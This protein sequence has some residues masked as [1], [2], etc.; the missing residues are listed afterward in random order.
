MRK[1]FESQGSYGTMMAMKGVIIA[2]HGDVVE[3]EFSGGLPNINDSLVVRKSDETNIILEVHDHISS[4]VV[5][6][7]ALGYTQGLKRG[8]SVVSSGSSLKIPVDK[9]CLG[10][11]FNI[12]GEPIDGKP[13][14]ENGKALPIHKMPPALTEQIP[15]SGILET[16]IKIID[17]LS[18][19]P[20]GGKIGL[21]GGAGVGKTVL[22]MEFIYK[23]AKVYSGISIFCG[24]GERVREG[25]ELW[26]EMERQDI[27]GNA[28]L[29]FGEMCE[30]PGIRFRVPLTA[31]T[32]AEF[33]R[34]EIGKDILF[35]MDNIYRFVQ[36]GN[37]VSVLLG[38]LSSRVGYQ[39]TL[40]SELA[41]VEE[42]IVSTPRGSITSIQAIYVPADDITDPAVANVFPHLDTTVVLSRD[43]AAKGLYPAIDPLLSTSKFLSP[44]GVGVRHYGISRNVKEH[45]SRYKELLDIIAMLGIEELS[46]DDRLIVKRARKLEMFLTQPFFLT[47]EFTGREGKHV[48]LAKT[49]DGCEMILSGKMDDM[50]ENAFFMI[51]DVGEIR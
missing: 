12:F 43:I 33:F 4:T 23:I 22:L 48:P 20:R 46:P 7:I 51:G 13:P 26:R 15:A 1:I 40:L 10:R 50:S 47:K 25:H 38:R 45:L 29:V 5:K 35:L 32:L 39:P 41:E 19:F 30:S 17:L 16:G 42:R 37:E 27:I 8:M 14:L 2:I 21:F 28:M 18:P 44:E 3:I 49:L 6:A 31:I 36:A 34:D 9:N 24:I 11:A